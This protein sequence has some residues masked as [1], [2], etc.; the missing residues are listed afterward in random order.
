MIFPGIGF[1][2]DP[3]EHAPRL[4]PAPLYHHVFPDADGWVMAA[5]ISEG[6]R[7][8][9]DGVP[10]AAPAGRAAL[11]LP[12]LLHHRD[13]VLSC[14]QDDRRVWQE[15][16]TN[17]PPARMTQRL[18]QLREHRRGIAVD[19]PPDVARRAPSPGSHAAWASLGIPFPGLPWTHPDAPGLVVRQVDPEDLDHL[20]AATAALGVELARCPDEAAPCCQPPEAHTWLA[21]AHRILPEHVWAFTVTWQGTPIQFELMEQA[22]V[23]VSVATWHLT[24]ERPA[25][26]WREA[27][28]PIADGLR[29]L[30]HATMRGLIRGDLTEW[31][32][33]LKAEYGARPVGRYQ[34][35]GVQLEYDLAAIRFDGLPA[36]RTVPVVWV[37]PGDASVEVR[38]LDLETARTEI[39]RLWTAR[40]T[41]NAARNMVESLRIA[42]ERWALDRASLL[43]GFI[44]GECEIVVPLSPRS[45]DRAGYAT[46][47]PYRSTPQ[48]GLVQLGILR[49]AEAAGYTTAS[50]WYLAHQAAL[51]ES[52]AL[53]RH[54]P[55][56]LGRRRPNA[57]EGTVT[58]AEAL[59][60]PT[61]EWSADLAVTP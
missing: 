52:G 24:P 51:L 46:C 59:A 36:R 5:R 29:D 18:A 53:K 13:G 16:R 58:I 45:A 10:V 30:G 57:V 7:H 39:T 23:P 22:P 56:T 33:V 40:K 20:A 2:D 6:P 54:I 34:G 3:A 50:T 9:L 4:P 48:A 26:F 25:W 61:A 14:P 19:L 37:A 32:E 35:G 38:E 60:R 21:L 43:G 8:G 47:T 31:I 27:W 44:G 12:G 11:D 55:W 28:R 17:T 49:W 41:P 1:V 42:E 15:L